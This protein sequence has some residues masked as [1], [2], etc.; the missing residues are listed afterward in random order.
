MVRLGNNFIE[1]YRQAMAT[2]DVRHGD[3][4]VSTAV[5][6]APPPSGLFKLNVDGACFND[7]GKDSVAIESLVVLVGLQVAKDRGFHDFQLESDSAIVCRFLSDCS[8]HR[9]SV[10]AV[11]QSCVLLMDN[12]GVSLCSHEQ[13]D[14]NQVAH[15]MARNSHRT[16]GTRVWMGKVPAWA[17]SSL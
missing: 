8:F 14:L 10:R 16:L 13:R 4:T 2:Q 1:D 3:P 9:A 17:M 5:V 12:L 11:L 15:F 7:K 6:W